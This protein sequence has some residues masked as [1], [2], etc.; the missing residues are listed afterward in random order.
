MC[1][2]D[3][4]TSA[5]CIPL[6]V[7]IKDTICHILSRRREEER[8]RLERERERARLEREREAEEVRAR[9]AEDWRNRGRILTTPT[10]HWGFGS[11]TIAFIEVF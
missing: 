6:V 7:N 11:R 10:P 4:C 5:M 9:E 2:E 1:W 3:V 8:A